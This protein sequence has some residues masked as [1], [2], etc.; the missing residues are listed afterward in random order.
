MPQK[1]LIAE[2]DSTTLALVETRLRA[3]NYDVFVATHSDE[4]MRLVQKVR[5]DLVLLG[6][7]MEQIEASDLSKKIKQSLA[8]LG[9][10]IILM[11]DEH[12]LRQLVMS[13]ERGFDDFLIKPFDAY[14]LQL[15]ISL[16]L[17]RARE[18][19]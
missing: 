1:I 14:S 17:S 8:G 4:A 10:P 3:R 12:E 16:N 11:A 6:S 13:Q 2:K 9:V 19:L 7:S 15:R 5:F 18:R